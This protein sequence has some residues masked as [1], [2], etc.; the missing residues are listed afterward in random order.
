MFRNIVDSRDVAFEKDVTCLVGKNESGKT[1]M[2]SALYRMNPAST[3]VGLDQ[4]KDYPRWRYTRDRKA[5]DIEQV[6]PI[7]CLFELEDADV[8]AV[9]AVFGPK[10]LTSLHY[11]RSLRY[12]NT[13]SSC[14]PFDDH[15]AVTNVL[16]AVAASPELRE[17]LKEYT[18]LE[19]VLE[20]CARLEDE[21]VD[22]EEV[23]R[24]TQLVRQRIGKDSA[25][26]KARTILQDRVPKF[27][28]FSDYQL[29]PGRVRLRDLVQSADEPASSPLQTARALLKLAGADTATLT[30]EEFDARKS[31]LEAV[32]NELTRQ[33]FEY[34]KQ[35]RGLSVE[36]DVD[37]VIESS[38][39]YNGQT[40]VAEFLEVRVRDSRHGFTNN[41]DQRSSGFQW[42]FSFLAAFSEFENHEH[43]VIVLL[44]EPALTL[45][46][47]AQAD[48]LRFITE[49]LAASSQVVYTT[50]SP[51]IVESSHLDRVR[52]V[53]DKGPDD[54]AVVSQDVYSVGSE[55]L[56][57]LQAALGY[58][59]A[60]NLFVGPDNLLVEGTSDFTYLRLLSD[61]LHSL[62]R[63]GLSERWRMI[64]SAG[65]T[66]MPT[67]VSLLGDKL[68]VTLLIDGTSVSMGKLE[69]LIKRKILPAKRLIVTDDFAPMDPSDIEDLFSKSEYLKLYN[70]ALGTSLKV[71]D[72]NGKDRVIA[73]IGRATGTPF[74]EHGRPAEV[75]LRDPK[76]E[77]F[78]GKL[79][80]ATLDRFEALFKTINATL[81]D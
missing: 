70:Q 33:V 56:F 72:L 79:S 77:Q 53:E 71:R 44:D 12:D 61:H 36:I 14:V 9:E 48:F 28:Y 38:G 15:V 63:E 50:H 26:A 64:Q 11:S 55:S 7:S 74:K 42:F 43:G 29:L 32:S 22:S 40:A 34:W 16:E 47:R 54:G 20:G 66:N 52:I 76:R 73:Q 6:C 58:D 69:N 51:F 46:G 45:H 17:T 78:L 5:G 57:P 23:D 25:V 75:L 60:Q 10:V 3:G 2:L 35:N 49:R 8:E 30:A 4:L 62:G 37:K 80:D 41:F 59:I 21:D 24:L 65:T 18:T 39:P 19:D 1:A 68:D 27:F 13:W 31:E 67:F 81:S